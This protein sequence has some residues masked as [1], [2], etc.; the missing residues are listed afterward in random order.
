MFGLM[1]FVLTSKDIQGDRM[2]RIRSKYVLTFVLLAFTIAVTV[3]FMTSRCDVWIARFSYCVVSG[4]DG[5]P[6]LR[7]NKEFAER[8]RSLDFASRVVAHFQANSDVKED[9]VTLIEIV[10]NAAI[11]VSHK[12]GGVVCEFTLTANARP[13]AEDVAR[14]C[15]SVMQNTIDD[16][17]RIRA[18]KATSELSAALASHED[19]VRKTREKHDEARRKGADG[20]EEYESAL[21]KL[22]SE[23]DALRRSITEIEL[24][25]S[26]CDDKLVVVQ[27]L[28]VER[29]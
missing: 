3:F 29:K 13:L 25:V 16:D 6:F 22:T 20:I 15:L 10:T 12:N 21:E 7:S 11:L 27:Q 23:C 2:R 24:A 19:L 4:G 18:T 28:S 5:M 1:E 17:N 14:S 26:R 8:V 9:A